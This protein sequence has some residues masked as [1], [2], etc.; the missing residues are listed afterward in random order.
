MTPVQFRS[1]LGKLD[2]TQVEAARLV[3]VNP[4]TV[5]D[6]ISGETRIPEA[7]AILLR[8]MIKMELNQEDVKSDA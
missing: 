6:W 3:C 5:R 2:I 4:R 1:A 8:F 7:V